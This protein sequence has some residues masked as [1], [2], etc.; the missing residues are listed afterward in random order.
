MRGFG[1]DGVGGLE[2]WG[3]GAGGV[4]KRGLY[5][6]YVRIDVDLIIGCIIDVSV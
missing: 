6:A 4:E 1:E 2:S 5:Y 3:V